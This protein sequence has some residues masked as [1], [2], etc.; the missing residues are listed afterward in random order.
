M[1][2]DSS[3]WIELIAETLPV[4]A[5]LEFVGNPVAGG[6]CAFVGTTRAQ[7]NA[8]GLDLAALDYEAYREMALQQMHDLAHRARDHWPVAKIALLHRTGRVEVGH[9]SVVIAVACPHR[10]EA[11]AA[12]RWL[13]DTL[14]TEAPIWKRQIWSDGTARWVE[15]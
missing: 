13:I 14:K 8:A 9:A 2:P 11:F 15:P 4:A 6:T 10:A 12:C 1:Q 5:A 3:D 7:R